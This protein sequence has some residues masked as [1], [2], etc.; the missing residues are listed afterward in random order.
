MKPSERPPHDKK[1]AAKDERE[2]EGEEIRDQD[3]DGVAGGEG[4]APRDPA[5]GL[6]S[7][8]RL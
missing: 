1:P 7:G 8:K 3:L 4:T 2:P 6:P 5:T